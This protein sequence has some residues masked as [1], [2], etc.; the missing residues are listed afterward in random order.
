MSKRTPQ[1][2]YSR[3][4]LL[5]AG[6]G[7]A[8]TLAATSG[9]ALAQ[10]GNYGGY[11][12]GA[13]N[14]DGR[15][16]D[17]TGEDSVTVDV[18]AGDT[19]L[20][21]GPAAINVDPGTEVTWEWTGK[22][23][24]HNVVAEDESFTSGDPVGD[25]GTTF[26]YTFEEEG[27]YQYYCNPHK[28]SGMR[29]VVAVGDTAEGDVVAPDELQSEGDDGGETGGGSTDYDFDG[30]LED[31]MNYD[32]TVEDL[33]GEDSVTVDVGAG[34][35]G[36]AFG[37][38]AIHI[39]PGTTVT[40]EWTGEGGAHNVVANTGAFESGEPQTSGTYE[41]TFEEDGT[42]TYYC[43]PHEGAGMKGA[44]VVGE[45]GDVGGDDSGATTAAN[46]L[47]LQTLAA[48]LVLGLLSPIIF[49]L[50]VRRKMQGAPRP[51]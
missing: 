1:Q 32:G 47:A 41:Y 9:T 49:L 46:D 43:R 45:G 5:K 38:A 31:A 26:S 16:A 22:G 15:T 23:G 10:D 14:Y 50:F 11:L 28:A 8:V 51:E 2:T 39:D 21:F 34:D 6:T 7:A 35:T 18:G 40:W 25:E 42:H 37:P 33:R 3:R 44:V 24:A 27:V 36:L 12:E 4:T 20:A 30:Y 13:M 17:Y 48:M 19:N 29:G